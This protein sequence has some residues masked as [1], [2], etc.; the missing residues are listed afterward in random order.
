MSERGFHLIDDDLSEG[1]LESFV[2]QGLAE[3]EAYL[4]KHSDFQ[5]F[6]EDR[7]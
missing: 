5:T 3:V 1:W 6:L 7:D 4:R 2:A